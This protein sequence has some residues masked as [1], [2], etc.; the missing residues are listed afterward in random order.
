M[1][2]WMP[3]GDDCCSR[4]ARNAAAAPEPQYPQQVDVGLLGTCEAI[5]CRSQPFASTSSLMMATCKCRCDSQCKEY[6]H[7]PD[8]MRQSSPCHLSFITSMHFLNHKIDQENFESKTLPLKTAQTEP[9]I[10]KSPA[11]ASGERTPAQCAKPSA[12]SAS[13]IGWTAIRPEHIR[14]R[15]ADDP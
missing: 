5:W 12:P 10:S 2:K 1:P 15:R 8:I 14:T 4:W 6:L 9:K 11:G 7:F 3:P 13:A